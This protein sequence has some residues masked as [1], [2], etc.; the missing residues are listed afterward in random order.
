MATWG[1]PWRPE[2][3]DTTRGLI[4][5]LTHAKNLYGGHLGAVCSV[6]QTPWERGCL[7]CDLDALVE[8]LQMGRYIFEKRLPEPTGSW[9]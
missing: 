8:A 1:K 2:Q 6:T 3:C 5:A 9:D 4:A 7:A